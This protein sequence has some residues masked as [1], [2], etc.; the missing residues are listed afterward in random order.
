[1]RHFKKDHLRIEKNGISPIIHTS[2]DLHVHAYTD[3]AT[4]VPS[5]LSVCVTIRCFN[6]LKKTKFI[7]FLKNEQLRLRNRN[8]KMPNVACNTSSFLKIQLYIYE[9]CGD[10]SVE[11]SETAGND[12][13]WSRNVCQWQFS[14]GNGEARFKYKICAETFP[15]VKMSQCTVWGWTEELMAACEGLTT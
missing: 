10:S 1:M 5:S 12:M 3:L 7:I 13:R 6:I 15:R 4:S 2:T 8:E 11:A 9:D 14:I